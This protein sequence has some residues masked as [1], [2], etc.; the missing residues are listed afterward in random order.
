[1]AFVRRGIGDSDSV[2]NSGRLSTGSSGF[3]RWFAVPIAMVA[4]A[5]WGVATL[6]GLHSAASLAYAG[7]FGQPALSLAVRKPPAW[8]LGSRKSRHAPSRWKNP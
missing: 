6:A 3:V 1:M 5:A 8:R 4:L 7:S 2:I